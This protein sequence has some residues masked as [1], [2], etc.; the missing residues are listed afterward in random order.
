MIYRNWEPG[1]GS[2]RGEGKLKYQFETWCARNACETSKEKCQVVAG[3]IRL[4]LRK[5]NKT[6]NKI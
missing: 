3:Y 1:G 6:G 5:G 2:N 4:V